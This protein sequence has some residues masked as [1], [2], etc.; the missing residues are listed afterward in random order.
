MNI[1]TKADSGLRPYSCKIDKKYT[2]I[3][4][5]ED[6]VSS[7]FIHKRYFVLYNSFCVLKNA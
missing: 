4:T 3:R 7:D 1:Q 6:D 2:P 5:P